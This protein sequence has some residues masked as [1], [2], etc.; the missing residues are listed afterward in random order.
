MIVDLFINFYRKIFF[1]KVASHLGSYFTD[2][3][4]KE[5]I[6]LWHSRLH[7]VL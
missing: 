4:L 2:L 5:A 1:M 7:F 3:T 6:L